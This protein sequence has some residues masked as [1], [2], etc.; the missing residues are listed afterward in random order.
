MKT[1]RS[2]NQLRIFTFAL[3]LIFFVTPS[4][5]GETDLMDVNKSDS[6]IKMLVFPKSLRVLESFKDGETNKSFS[7]PKRIR[8]TLLKLDPP[9]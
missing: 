8:K 6:T 7:D 5:W 4:V 2:K 3:L 9:G 1:I